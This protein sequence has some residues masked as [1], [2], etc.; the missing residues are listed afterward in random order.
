MNH[1]QITFWDGTII[2]TGFNG[3]LAEAKAYYLN[4]KFELHEDQPMVKAVK[5][6]E[7]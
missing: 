2:V 1:F 6:E 3:N 7:I 4:N 5:V